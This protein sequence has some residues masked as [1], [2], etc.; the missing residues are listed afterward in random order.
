MPYKTSMKH[1]DIDFTKVGTRPLDFK[2]LPKPAEPITPAK[3][4]GDTSNN[5]P[6]P[7]QAQD[8]PI[9]GVPKPPKV[10]DL[11]VITD[12]HGWYPYREGGGSAWKIGGHW[13]RVSWGDH[14]ETVTDPT[15]GTV[16]K[17]AEHWQVPVGKVPET[18]VRAYLRDG[19]YYDTAT[20]KQIMKYAFLQDTW[21]GNQQWAYVDESIAGNIKTHG[22]KGGFQ[23]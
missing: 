11:H 12:E 19:K 20:G 5:V 3:K 8:K 21:K 15:T 13:H 17:H 10:Y 9:A 6:N 23:S 22:H 1:H 2:P 18:T 4:P 14:G 16:W 7:S